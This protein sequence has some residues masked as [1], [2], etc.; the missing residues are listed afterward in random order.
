MRTRP[1]RYLAA[2]FLL[3][4][5]AIVA[6]QEQAGAMDQSIRYPSERGKYTLSVTSSLEPIPINKMHEWTLHLENAD[7]DPVDGAEL[8]V[9][10]GMPEHDHGLPTSPRVTAN[11]GG[12]DYRLQGIRF[13]M[14]GNWQIIIS[15]FDGPTSDRVVIDLKL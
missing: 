6:A 10:G 9:A 15:I 4:S 14:K 3:A 5:T 13:H 7:G 12:G 1:D 11:T 8:S 2:L